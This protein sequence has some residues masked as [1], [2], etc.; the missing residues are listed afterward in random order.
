MLEEQ[1]K[2][3]ER[4]RGIAND[5]AYKVGNIAA[6]IADKYSALVLQGDLRNIRENA[7]KSNSFNKKFSL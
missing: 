4:V 6:D 1:L 7:R 3:D 2:H 5:Y